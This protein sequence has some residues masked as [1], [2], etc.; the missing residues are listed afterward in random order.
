MGTTRTT[1]RG[2]AGG[3]CRSALGRREHVRRRQRFVVAVAGGHLVARRGVER[4]ARHDRSRPTDTT[5]SNTTGPDPTGSEAID[6]DVAEPDATGPATTV[7]DAAQPGADEPDEPELGT[8]SGD[9][10]EPA[11]SDEA[12]TQTETVEASAEE[13]VA[14]TSYDTLPDG[15]P[16]PALVIFDD[17]LITLSGAVPSQPAVDRLGVL[18]IANS[19][20]PDAEV[21]SF[22]TV[23]PTVPIGVGVRVIE[24]N[25]PRFSEGSP[26]ITP[27][28]AEQLDRVVSIMT[29][30]PNIS[31]EVI[32]HSDQ[33][34]DDAANFTLSTERARAAA[35]Y[36]SSRGIDPT[37]LTSR[38][39]GESDLLT[40]NNDAAAL[41]LNRRTEFVFY[42]LLVDESEPG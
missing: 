36:L 12:P 11:A 4:G 41:A 19:T 22:L 29:A 32:G 20:V 38:G 30:L 39:A 8:A 1:P 34:G 24:M 13:P 7:S 14:A 27:E 9:G 10:D 33:R 3:P 25:S 18:A 40:L 28:H 23:D 35:D 17:D 42:G 26:A 21:A 2:S 6:S 16:V 31:A 15:R 37:R 5:E